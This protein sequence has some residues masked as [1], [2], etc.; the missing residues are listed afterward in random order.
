MSD[1]LHVLAQGKAS[2]SIVAGLSRLGRRTAN[3]LRIAD[4]A[5]RQ[6]WALAV[7]DLRVNTTTPT[8]RMML[9][10]LAA[11]AQLERDRTAERTSAALTAA[12]RRR[13]TPR[14]SRQTTHG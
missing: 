2:V 7:L 9:T 12:K 5:D 6:G 4:L 3:V 14:R 13:A 11:V 8:G 1:A 10:V